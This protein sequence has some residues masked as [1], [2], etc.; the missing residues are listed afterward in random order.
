MFLSFYNV[1]AVAGR[2]PLISPFSFF[3]SAA[4][5]LIQKNTSLL[6]PFIRN[7]KPH[8]SSFTVNDGVNEIRPTYFNPE[9]HQVRSPEVQRTRQPQAVNLVV[10]GNG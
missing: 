3:Q 10:F 1:L 8:L 2:D 7:D 4:F 6:Q 9:V 5:G